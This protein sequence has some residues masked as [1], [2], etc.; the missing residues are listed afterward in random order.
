LQWPAEGLK[1]VS[2]RFI[3]AFTMETTETTKQALMSHMGN[4]HKIT[5]DA[6]QEYF[7][8]FRRYVYVTPKSYLSFIKNYKTVYSKEHSGVKVL[9]DKVNNGLLKLGQAEKDVAK[10]K[11]ELAEK[12]IIL[13]EAQ[14]KSA[15]LLQEI[16]VSTARAEKTKK[17]VQVVKDSAQATASKIG[18]EKADVEE[19]LK[20]A[21][22]AL[23]EAEDALKAITAKDIQGLKA[24]KTPPDVI[25]VVFDGVL[26]LKRRAN[27]GKWQETEIKGFKVCLSTYTEST[28]M[29]SEMTF[30]TKP[31]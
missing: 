1:N 21:K 2:E 23:I 29:M 26:I 11:I 28:K 27:L 4:V 7:E 16:T 20:L 3:G 5:Q 24:L 10:M 9:A 18:K 12:E 25:K 30:L 13:A 6:C 8:K 31:S 22:P 15:A 17:E 14:K 19:D